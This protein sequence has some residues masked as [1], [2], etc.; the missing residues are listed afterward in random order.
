MNERLWE[1]Y[2]AVC[3]DEVRPLGEFID[4]LLAR[5]WGSYPKDDVLELIREI[6]S[7]VLSNIQVKALEGPRYA[8]QAEAVSEQTQREFED[9]ILRV[10]QAPDPP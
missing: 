2:L 6:E 3:Q 4:R 5:E 9:L 10:E 1:L 7:Q 8:E